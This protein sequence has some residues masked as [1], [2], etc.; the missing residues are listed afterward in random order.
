MSGREVRGRWKREQKEWPPRLPLLLPPPPS[1]GAPAARRSA[2]ESAEN[3]TRGGTG[4]CTVWVREGAAACP[5]CSG[6]DRGAGDGAASGVREGSGQRGGRGSPSPALSGGRR[7]ESGDGGAAPAAFLEGRSETG[8]TRE[9][10]GP[11][12]PPGSRGWVLGL[13]LGPLG[14]SRHRRPRPFLGSGPFVSAPRRWRGERRWLPPSSP[15]PSPVPGGR[16][17]E[18]SPPLCVCVSVCACAFKREPLLH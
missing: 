17:G 3:S 15:P 2:G 10:E 7:G 14:P 5:G 11:K 16:R 8:H 1:A 12:P 9:S 4:S 18:G 6:G 13:R